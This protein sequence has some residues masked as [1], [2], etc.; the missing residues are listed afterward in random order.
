MS[1]RL[2]NCAVRHD[3]VGLHRIHS[4]T[5]DGATNDNSETQS[6]EAKLLFVERAAAIVVNVQFWSSGSVVATH[7]NYTDDNCCK[8]RNIDNGGL[9][10]QFKI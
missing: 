10:V 1:P 3:I 5:L 8:C 6:F 2:S 7:K 4:N 9:K